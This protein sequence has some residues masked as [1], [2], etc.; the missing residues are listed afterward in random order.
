[1]NK[2]E[3]R[4]QIS[5]DADSLVPRKEFAQQAFPCETSLMTA[6][7][8]WHTRRETGMKFAFKY[9][10]IAEKWTGNAMNEVKLQQKCYCLF[11]AENASFLV[12]EFLPQGDMIQL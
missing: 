11:D 8:V 7:P 1:M 10:H 12:L 4:R 6:R 2:D 5:Q 9:I 3:Q